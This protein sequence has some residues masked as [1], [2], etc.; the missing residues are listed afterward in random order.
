MGRAEVEILWV[1]HGKHSPNRTATELYNYIRRRIF[2]AKIIQLYRIYS[3]GIIFPLVAEIMELR[4]DPKFN[5]RAECWYF[6]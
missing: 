2:T 3:T 4:Q 1:E 6:L 5:A